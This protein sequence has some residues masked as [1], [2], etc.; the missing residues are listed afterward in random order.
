MP[1]DSR[2]SDRPTRSFKNVEARLAGSL[3][4][5][6]TAF[7]SERMARIRRSGTEPERLVQRAARRCGLRLQRPTKRLPGSPDLAN[8]SRRVVVF[9]HG[10]FWHG[11]LGCPRA[12]VPS[13]NRMFWLAKFSRNRA[14]DRAATLALRR[15]GFQVVTIWECDTKD[16]S[17]LTARLRRLEWALRSTG[18]S[19]RAVHS[20]AR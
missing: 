13:R 17:R 2:A 15:L 18:R 11:H 4:P 14:R 20:K 3:T 16:P 19:R 1:R 10:C 12:T 7:D 8:L 5:R 9:V 6:T